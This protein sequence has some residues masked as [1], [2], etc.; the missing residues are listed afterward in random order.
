MAELS[1]YDVDI[2]VGGRPIV[3][4]ASVHV[5]PGELVGLIGPNGAGKSTLLRALCGLLPLARGSIRLNG[6]ETKEL[7]AH[8]LARQIAYLPQRQV[9]YW[10]L[11]GRQ[12]VELGRLPHVRAPAAEHERAIDKAVERTDIKDLIDQEVDTLSGGER[13]R[14]M[15]ARAL[16]VESDVLL[17][18]EPV[19]A[20]DPFH[21]LQI[22]E[23][24]RNLAREGMTVLIVLH[25]LALAMRF[26]D[27][28][29]LMQ[30]GLVTASGPASDVLSPDHLAI[31]Y[32]VTGIYS[33]TEGQR[34][35]VPW[36]RAKGLP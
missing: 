7:G 35:V 33:E 30:D 6:Q 20:L 31:A 26:C 25:D 1:A 12:V 23:L 2:V 21:A 27:R 14:V 5:P 22:M 11:N 16:A 3:R 34:Y 13:A 29:F 9:L 36:R 17:A 15:L 8:A 19:A 18:D 4:N 10:Q 24:L 32:R 28:L